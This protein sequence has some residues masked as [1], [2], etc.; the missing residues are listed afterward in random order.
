MYQNKMNGAW[1]GLAVI[2]LHLAVACSSAFNKKTHTASGKVH[3]YSTITSH[4]RIACMGMPLPNS[5]MSLA[6]VPYASAH[7]TIYKLSVSRDQ[8]GFLSVPFFSLFCVVLTSHMIGM[9]WGCRPFAFL[10]LQ[11]KI[12]RNL[13]S[14][15]HCVSLAAKHIER[16]I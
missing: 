14:L 6:T 2:Q 3:C 4:I 12:T 13:F 5:F 15:F 7:I 16:K 10:H 1:L 9:P 11:H 8:P